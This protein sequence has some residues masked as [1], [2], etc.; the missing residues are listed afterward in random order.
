MLL[1]PAGVMGQSSTVDSLQNLLSS[2]TLSMVHRVDVMN[3]LAVHSLRKSPAQAREIAKEA[4]TYAEDID[5]EQ[6]IIHGYH[7]MGTAYWFER[8]YDSAAIC[9][10]EALKRDPE[11]KIR[12]S[13]L[14]NLG[15]VYT[16][17]LDYETAI[18]Y[19]L[20]ATQVA[21]IA[22]EHK[23]AILNNIA[24]IYLNQSDPRRG[25]NYYLQALEIEKQTGR[26]GNLAK[27]HQN[28]GNVY[29]DLGE[30]AKAESFLKEALRLQEKMENNSGKKKCYY[31]IARLRYKEQDTSKALLY[32]RKSLT[33]SREQEDEGMEAQNLRLIGDVYYY[34]KDYA[35][36]E[37]YYQT[38]LE[39]HKELE[40]MT[41]E[42]LLT[43]LLGMAYAQQGKRSAAE[44]LLEHIA[45]KDSLTGKERQEHIAQ[46][47]AKY[48]L[49]K[50]EKENETLR[51]AHSLQD[52]KLR[53]Q[54]WMIGTFSVASLLLM[55]LATVLFYQR[56]YSVRMH[57]ALK[58]KHREIEKMNGD[59][60]R[61]TS[62]LQV[63]NQQLVHSNDALSIAKKNLEEYNIHVKQSINYALRIQQALLPT[64]KM[65]N[66]LFG[67]TCLLFRPRDVVSGD[68]YWCAEKN[69][70]L[71]WAV[72][73][74]T[75]HGVPGAMMSM[76]GS[77]ALDNILKSTSLTD[78]AKILI[79]LQDRISLALK[80]S[81]TNINDGMDLAL[82]VYSP[83]ARILRYAGARNPLCYID[84]KGSLQ[85]VKGAKR[86]IGG[87]RGIGNFEMF[88]MQLPPQPTTIYLFS[89]GYK[90]QFGG[91]NNQRF[92]VKRFYR[93]L[94]SLQTYNIAQQSSVL[95]NALEEWMQAS[96]AKQLDDVLVWGVRL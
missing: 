5:Y 95:E 23:V 80:Q 30:Y 71:Y 50:K 7:K 38:S 88:E 41:G 16:K 51:Q 83:K 59:L 37:R 36:A 87:N 6:G 76:L 11:E 67:N 33:L 61:S 40:N 96:E 62:E 1:I 73:D 27:L 93:L 82:C 91:E 81:E 58:E 34:K 28:I 64:Q 44:L 31:A 63:L 89:D 29:T 75:G 78:P 68:F 12:V 8:N 26:K 84:E 19:Y 3:Q 22:L 18:S 42:V 45:L 4:L 32:A 70:F 85:V 74:C 79:A 13:L 39:L 53:Q 72:V 56:K 35:L 25:L 43:K 47:Q 65:V 55:A 49:F 54:Q 69:G 90:D 60:S 9:Y 48:D 20:Q 94:E 86:S 21:S 66:R 92:M 46:M 15:G 77:N 17:Q 52:A 24:V 14:N 57:R 2:D 10:K